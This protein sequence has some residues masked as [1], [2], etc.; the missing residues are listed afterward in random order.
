MR[1][2]CKPRR[3]LAL[4]ILCLASLASVVATASDTGKDAL[5]E[6]VRSEAATRAGQP[7]RLHV[8][9]AN[10]AGEWAVVVGEVRPAP[11]RVLDWSRAGDSDCRHDLD[12]GLWAVARQQ[13]GTWRIEELSLCDSEPRYW[14]L[15]E[16]GDMAFA[17]PCAIYRGLRVGATLTVEDQ[18]KAH[19]R[20][21]A[22]PGGEP[23]PGYHDGGR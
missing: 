12:K 21:A 15:E 17:R 18:C 2:P 5:L 6:R 10:L 9:T 19:V 23:S 4:G 7:V 14:Y 11:G 13:A 3:A 20:R 8:E 22:V 1:S 16:D